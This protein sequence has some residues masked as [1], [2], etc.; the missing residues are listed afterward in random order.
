MMTKESHLLIQRV[1]RFFVDV[2]TRDNQKGRESRLIK[3]E[4]QNYIYNNKYSICLRHISSSKT[5]QNGWTG[6]EQ[7]K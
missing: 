4:T 1:N 3:A 6:G 2:V 5:I 7:V